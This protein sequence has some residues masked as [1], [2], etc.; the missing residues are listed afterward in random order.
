MARGE[1]RPSHLHSAAYQGP[2]LCFLMQHQKNLWGPDAEVFDLD[3][4]LDEWMKYQT[5]NPFIFVSFIA[6]PQ[7]CLGQ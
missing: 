5:R 1:R 2:I 4:F 6:G 7:I 3:C